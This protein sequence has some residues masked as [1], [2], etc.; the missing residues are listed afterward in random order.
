MRWC[1]DLGPRMA[2]SLALDGQVAVAGAEGRE[3]GQNGL[4]TG[5][6]WRSEW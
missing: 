3:H 4:W 1:W 2:G 6:K 5:S